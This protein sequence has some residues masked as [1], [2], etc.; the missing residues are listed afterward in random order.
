MPLFPYS[1]GVAFVVV[2]FFK[3]LYTIVVIAFPVANG[4]V[5][6][7]ILDCFD[8]LVL[9]VDRPLAVFFPLVVAP[10]HRD[11]AKARPALEFAVREAV[12]VGD[13]EFLDAIVVPFVALEDGA[14]GVD[15]DGGLFDAVCM[16]CEDMFFGTFDG[17]PGETA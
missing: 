6:L 8:F 14:V 13:F 16:P 3:S 2:M 7:V 1:S 11:I 4:V 5:V 9:V 15:P 12:F 10:D 17:T